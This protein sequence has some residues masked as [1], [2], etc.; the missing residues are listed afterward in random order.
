MLDIFFDL[1][2]LASVILENWLGVR[3]VDKLV[4]EGD[5]VLS[6]RQKGWIWA[7]IGLASMLEY[8]NKRMGFFYSVNML[9]LQIIIIGTVLFIS[10][11]KKII[12]ITCVFI[13]FFQLCRR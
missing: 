13:M 3:F 8:L 5:R 12:S 1:V 11:R 7:A 9:G 10:R 6:R 4:F 2:L